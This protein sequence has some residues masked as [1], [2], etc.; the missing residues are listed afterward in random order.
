MR[1]LCSYVAVCVAFA[2]VSGC[3]TLGKPSE[4]EQ[5]HATVLKVKE[6]LEKRD[7]DL[8]MATFSEDFAH[9]QLG[10]KAEAREMLTGG[11]NSGYADN[12]EV[13]LD[14]LKITLADDKKTAKAY[15]LD[16]ASSA[17]AVSAELVLTKEEAG[18]LVTT[19]NVDG[20]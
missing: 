18:W 1:N 8:L 6:A 19:V 2:I 11:L 4:E 20:V 12:G 9:P 7:I 5:I 13:R 17:G 14:Q 10:G 16:L 3:A 15:P